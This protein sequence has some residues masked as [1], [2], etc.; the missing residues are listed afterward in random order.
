MEL[1]FLYWV[2]VAIIILIGFIMLIV[3][4]V[5]GTSIKRSLQVLIAGVICIVIGA[6]ACAY[7]LSNL[8]I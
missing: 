6:G 5:R 3:N 7:I 8:R 4:L 1:I 2:A